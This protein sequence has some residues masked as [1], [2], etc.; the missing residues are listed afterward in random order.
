MH[1]THIRPG[2]CDLRGQIIIECVLCSANRYSGITKQLLTSVS[3]RLEDVQ[4]TIQ[5]ILPEDAI[6][7]G[8]SLNGDLHAL[9]VCTRQ[10]SHTPPAWLKSLNPIKIE[11]NLYSC[12]FPLE[13]AADDIDYD[14]RV[15]QLFIE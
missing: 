13:G 15:P 4:E 6:L 8:Q 3:T 2:V 10:R 9:Q 14:Q 11:L 1:E 12:I 5:G 7:C